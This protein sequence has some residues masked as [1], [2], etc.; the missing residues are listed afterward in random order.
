MSGGLGVRLGAGLADY[1][2]ARMTFIGGGRACIGSKFSQLE[3]SSYNSS[4]DDIGLT[5]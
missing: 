2:G 1:G 5:N 3:M 4:N